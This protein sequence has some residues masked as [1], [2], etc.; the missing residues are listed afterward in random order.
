MN[1]KKINCIEGL[2]A[3]CWIGV[4]SC[5]FKNSFLPYSSIWMDGTPLRFLY[6]GNQCIRMLFVISGFLLSYKYFTEQNY[7]NGLKD[8]CKKYF[9]LMPAV[10]FTE[11][12]VCIFMS[13]GGVY[14]LE[15][16]I[17]SGSENFLGAYNQFKPNLFAC[18]KEALF[19][20]YFSGT[21]VY[22]EPLWVLKYE[23]LGT[24]LIIAV[25]VIFKKSSWRWLFY[26]VFLVAFNGYYNYFVLGMLICDL[27]INC[28][29]V[30][31]IKKTYFSYTM[32]IGGFVFFSLTNLND[33]D[34]YNRIVFA[35]GLILF[36]IGFLKCDAMDKVLGNR[37]MVGLGEISYFAYIIYLPV[38]E[39]LSC[40]LLLI[41]YEKIQYKILIVL[42]FFITFL[43][44]V[45]CASL[46]KYYI[47]AL[48]H[49]ISKRIE[50]I[51]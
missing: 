14:N 45:F 31:K 15:A 27:V 18:L 13:V 36:F 23:Y 1:E 46:M 35:I 17:I 49:C 30:E 2:K 38:I 29:I 16:S 9:Y 44:I 19:S 3:I 4:F 51:E 12:L 48:S 37:L 7:E 41:L 50:E 33:F 25:L 47:G 5:C 28:E 11:V 6:S 20:T 22:V 34:K 39:I 40:G 21:N 10:L 24:F 26:G 43:S 8:I 42:I 32:M